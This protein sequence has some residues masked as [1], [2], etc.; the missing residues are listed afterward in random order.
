MNT[1]RIAFYGIK[2]NYLADSPQVN[3]FALRILSY[4]FF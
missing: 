2:Y 4:V 1:E 3:L